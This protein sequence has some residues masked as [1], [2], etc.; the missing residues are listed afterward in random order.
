MKKTNDCPCGSGASYEKCCGPL[1]AGDKIAAT[2]EQLMRSR[3]TANVENNG[4]YLLASYHVSTRPEKSATTFNDW[5]QLQ[6]LEVVNGG[7][8]NETGVVEFRAL[9]RQGTM[10]G[11]LHERSRFC[12]E[13]G[14]WY[15]LDGELLD[16]SLTEPKKVGRNSPCPCGSGKK[17]KKCCL[18]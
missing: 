10:Q 6:I 3:F 7:S 9:Y 13:D 8:E 16:T 17:Y 15:Y 4:A 12:K 2:A 14:R 18:G 11:V 5:F 1:L